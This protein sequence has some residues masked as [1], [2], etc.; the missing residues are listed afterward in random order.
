MRI[1]PFDTRRTTQQLKYWWNVHWKKISHCLK[2]FIKTSNHI[3]QKKNISLKTR[4]YEQKYNLKVIIQGDR[5]N[6][7]GSPCRPVFYFPSP[8]T[9]D[10]ILLVSDPLLQ[11][12]RL[13]YFPLHGANCFKRGTSMVIFL[14][15][16]SAK[17]SPSSHVI[18]LYYHIWD[19][20]KSKPFFHFLN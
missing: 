14:F 4:S 1:L 5:R 15:Q 18:A 8:L 7:M 10:A 13:F 12:Q 19:D 20:T 3:I 6:Q 16:S 2:Q 9:T 17:N 11:R